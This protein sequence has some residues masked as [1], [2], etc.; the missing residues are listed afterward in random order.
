MATSHSSFS[1]HL[2]TLRQKAEAL[3]QE[4]ASLCGNMTPE[5]FNWKPSPDSWSVGQCVHHLIVFNTS[6]FTS[7]DKSIE[8]ARRKYTESGLEPAHGAYKAGMLGAFLIR[9]MHPGTLKVRTPQPFRPS[10]S[11]IPLSALRDFSTAQQHLSEI[12][13]RAADINLNRTRVASPAAGLLRFRL[14]DILAILL[15]HE[16]RHMEQIRKITTHASFPIA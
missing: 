9:M 3:G 6:Y 12:L 15:L 8:R 1:Q 14:G 2:H 11:D 4:I 7:L 10:Q 16:R 13:L 5:Q